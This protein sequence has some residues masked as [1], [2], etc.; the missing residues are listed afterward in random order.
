MADDD[1][2]FEERR[3][4]VSP[5]LE[6]MN[7]GDYAEARKRLAEAPDNIREAVRMTVAARTSILL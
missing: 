7:N 3:D 6:S 2:K 4:Y 5:V 1:L